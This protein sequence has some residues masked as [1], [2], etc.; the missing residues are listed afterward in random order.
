MSERKTKRKEK[1]GRRGEREVETEKRKRRWGR[2]ER[3]GGERE[4]KFPSSVDHG[5]LFVVFL[6]PCTWQF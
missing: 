5:E 2:E 1:K 3:R 4:V 6:S